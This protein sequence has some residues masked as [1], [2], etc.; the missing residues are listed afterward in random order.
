VSKVE[1]LKKEYVRT[2]ILFAIVIGGVIVFQLG[3]RAAL[4]THYPLAAVESPSMVPTLNVGDII[5]VR[6]GQNMS[7]IESG[8]VGGNP[9]GDIIVFYDPRGTTRRVYWFF[10][11]PALIV[12]RAI[13]K[14]YDNATDMWY[15]QTKGDNNPSP[16]NWDNNPYT[17]CDLPGTKIVGK[18]GG[19]IPW[20]GRISLFMQSDAGMML[21]VL[22]FIAI[23]MIDYVITPVWESLKSE[24]KE[25]LND[26]GKGVS[27]H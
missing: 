10:K 13:D 22:L 5:V 16:D 25:D 1:W 2:A 7:E 6:G 8:S 14:K 17:S 18:V 27:Q 19:R 4:R 23:I 21:I 12:H 9:V 26:K 24:K 3:L 20:M 11:A 15:F